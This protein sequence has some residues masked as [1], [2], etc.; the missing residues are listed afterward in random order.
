[1]GGWLRF[2]QAWPLGDIGEKV[3]CMVSIAALFLA[4]ITG[5]GFAQVFVIALKN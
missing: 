4:R 5:K 2:L 3:P 1:M